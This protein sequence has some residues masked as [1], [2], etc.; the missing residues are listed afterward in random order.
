[1]RNGYWIA[2]LA[3][4]AFTA[5]GCEDADYQSYNAA[6]RSETTGHLHDSDHDKG[7]VGKHGGHIL[8]LDD[9]HA[10]HAE[11]VFD[12]KT[13]DVTVYFCGAEVGDAKPASK[14]TLGL[15][16]SGGHKEI[17]AKPIPLEGEAAESSS[18]WVF[19]GANLPENV[20]GEEQLDGHLEAT[21]DGKQFSYGLE[22]HSHDNDEHNAAG[23]SAHG[24]H[25][26]ADHK[27]DEH[28]RA[29]P[30]DKDHANEEVKQKE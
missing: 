19:S 21:I 9:A 26:D 12:A 5:A 28:G 18:C 8:E 14:V 27:S 3:V 1:M 16:V 22:P 7:V 6:P 10:H 23:E 24:E 29:G 13:R 11:L 2:S 17:V 25:G 4:A 20:K 15:H 30:S